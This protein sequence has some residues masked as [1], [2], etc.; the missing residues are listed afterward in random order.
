M[1]RI[2]ILLGLLS[3]L[4]PVSAVADSGWVIT[5]N[6]IDLQILDDGGLEVTE[7]I[8]AD[9]SMYKHGIIRLLPIRYSVGLHQYALRLRLLDVIDKNGD[10]YTK[11]LKNQGNAKRLRIGDPNIFLK[12]ENVYVIRYRVDRAILWEDDRAILRWNAVGLEWDVPHEKVA[13][14]VH[15]AS[16]LG[17]DQIRYDAWTGYYGSV[18]R[19]YQAQRNNDGSIRFEVEA[20]KRHEGMTVSISMPAESIQKPGFGK[21]AGWFL[22]D[23][24]GY[25]VFPLVVLV[26]LGM[27][28]WRGRDLAG[29]GTIVV[30]YGPPSEFNPTEV[31]TLLDERVD[32]RDIS[33]TI[34]SFATRGMMS[35]E[36]TA[37]EL[38]S[39]DDKVIFR[40][41]HRPDDLNTHEALLFDTIFCTGEKVKLEDLKGSYYA[42]LPRVRTLVYKDLS[43]RGYFDGNPES[44]RNRFLGL[45]IPILL[46]ALGLLGLIQHLMLGQVFLFPIILTAVLS[47][48]VL[49]FTSRAMP[50]RT[51]KGRQVWEHIRGLEEYIQRA[52]ATQIASAEKVDVFERLLP[53]AMILG[54][55]EKWANTFEG[56]YSEPPAWYAG[57]NP[58]QTSTHALTNYLNGTS[59]NIHNAMFTAPRTESSSSGGGGGWSSGGFSGGGSSGGGFGGGGGSSW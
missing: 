45:G 8:T 59:D 6:K 36:S 32:L 47:L 48:G 41:I 33:A 37:D 31:G 13:V 55:S 19:N 44:R 4:V 2:F 25:L 23:N 53:Y 3:L 26:C 1:K 14:T 27:W 54:L 10:E 9:F 22:F 12:G 21:R 38:S 29:R 52:E 56:I 49:I 18:A 50:R 57:K 42:I 30:Q 51:S 7:I 15:L 39:S 5:N 35:I 46:G 58:S 17:D 43:K 34:I 16:P 28:L 40:K 24:S 20:L 11:Q